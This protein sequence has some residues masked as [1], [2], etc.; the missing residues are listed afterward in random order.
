MELFEAERDREEFE[1]LLPEALGWLRSMVEINSFTANA[2]GVN[3]L[4]LLTAE[5]FAT[6]GFSAEFVPSEDTRFGRHLLL[7]GGAPEGRPV[8]CVSHLDTV[9]PEEE[10][11]RHGFGWQEVV[12]EGRIYGPGTVDIKGGTVLIWMLFRV[13]MKRFPEVFAGVRWVVALNA[14][15]EVMGRDFGRLVSARCAG[16]AKGV[17]VFEGG[18]RV[19]SEYQLVTAR[20]GR[21]EYEVRALGR[22]AHAGSNHAEGI[23][24]VVALA[25]AIQEAAALTDYGRG[26]TVNVG[27]VSGGTV[28]NRVPHEAMMELEMRAFAPEVLEEARQRLAGLEGLDFGGAQLEVKCRGASPAWPRSVGANPLLRCWVEASRG[29]GMEI[30]DTARGGLSDANYL[31]HLGPTLDGLGP[32]GANAHCSERS[33][34]GSRVP[35]YVEPDSLITKGVLNLHGL[36]R[37][38]EATQR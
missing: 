20:K 9:Y 3:H 36:R 7:S 16:E 38:M 12:S 27:S 22:G 19:G 5:A 2:D 31:H 24:A 30:R 13:L 11:R 6:L 33:A 26:L 34:D 37:W 21:A 35:E 29:L 18:P 25:S 17:L 10:E 15:E 1:A 23:N 8:V 28:V 32:S 14:S 4:G